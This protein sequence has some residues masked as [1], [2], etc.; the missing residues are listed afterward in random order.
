MRIQINKQAAVPIIGVVILVFFFFLGTFVSERN[1]NLK[2]VVFSHP[3]L[4]KQLNPQGDTLIVEE[5]RFHV[6]FEPVFNKYIISILEAP[7]E[8]I[9]QEAEIRFVE[10][11][12]LTQEKA[13]QLDV[14][15][16]TP[17]FANPQQSG[18]DYTISFCGSVTK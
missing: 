13:C 17:R 14:S 16:T 12:N 3:P 9:R 10:Q 15:V 8:E 6:A 7:F 5:K 1:S 4:P 2:P 11:F 18:K